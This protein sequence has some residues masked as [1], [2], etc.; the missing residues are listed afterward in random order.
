MDI[1]VS[2]L[3]NR[4]ALQLPAELPLGLVFVVG[5]V[6]ELRNGRAGQTT[7]LLCEDDFRL[8]CRLS[9]RAS[10]ENKVKEGSRIRAGGHLAFDPQRAEY[11]LLARDVEV[12]AEAEAASAVV[13]PPPTRPN[14]RTPL[15]PILDDIAKR[16]R[17]ASLTPA[18]LPGWVKDM[19]P[20]EMQPQLGGP[21]ELP[22]NINDDDWQAV[23]WEVGATNGAPPSAAAKS[24]P[25]AAPS[26]TAAP[27]SD[28][29]NELITFLSAAM[30]EDED[31]ELTSD[32]LAELAPQIKPEQTP[33]RVAHPYDLSQPE[34]KRIH[35]LIAAGTIIAL[36]LVMLFVAYLIFW[37]GII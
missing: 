26:P 12:I 30:D 33:F 28:L 14:A 25:P 3:N 24:E 1:P 23:D 11:Y 37:S 32:L 5:A 16:A 20:P 27:A 17:A 34:P 18:N 8:R 2:R 15:S 9:E 7:F 19:A 36:L 22:D 21:V 29:N 4:M 10:Q 35:W 6:E 13:A 31:V